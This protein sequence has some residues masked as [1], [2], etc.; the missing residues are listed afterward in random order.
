MKESGSLE[1]DANTILLIYRPMD[2]FGRPT[3]DDEIV[4]AKQRHGPVGNERVV[5]DAKTLTFHQREHHRG[6]HLDP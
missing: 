2:D 5:F 6:P 4:I 3:G 1:N